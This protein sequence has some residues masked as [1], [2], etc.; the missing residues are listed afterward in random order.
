M[1]SDLLEGKIELY[2]PYIKT[3]YMGLE[4]KALKKY[5][6]RELY[7]AQLL[8]NEQIK[9]L[10]NFRNARVKNLPTSILF[11]KAFI[12]FSK[13]LKTAKGFLSNDKI[14]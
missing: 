11:S 3:L 8:S 2:L 12:S 14:A 13:K 7:S 9:D 1:K 10:Q 4:K 5:V 6:G